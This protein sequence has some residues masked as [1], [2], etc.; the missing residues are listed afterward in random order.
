[1]VKLNNHIN[2]IFQD[3]G[4]HLS[5]DQMK[6]YL[7]HSLGKQEERKIEI[8]IASCGLC[9]EALEGLDMENDF[10]TFET[11]LHNLQKKITSKSKIKTAKIIV[12]KR[13]YMAAAAIIL[14]LIAV[15]FMVYLK[16]NER[17]A[18]EVFAQHYEK[19]DLR[20]GLNNLA[21][22]STDEPETQKDTLKASSRNIADTKSG[23]TPDMTNADAPQTDQLAE[24]PVF[25]S[26][27][28]VIDSDFEESEPLLAKKSEYPNGNNL[29][30][31]E[32]PSNYAGNTAPLSV[33]A[34]TNIVL[35]QADDMAEPEP[36]LKGTYQNDKRESNAKTE[37]YE[38][39]AIDEDAVISAYQADRYQDCINFANQLLEINKN[40]DQ[41]RFY[42]GLSF[43]ALQYPSRAIEDFDFLIN[44]HTELFMDDAK[45]YKALA[46]LDK[47]KKKK[48]I[49]LLKQIKLS[50]SKYAGKA[51]NILDEM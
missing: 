48:A 16:V 8:H 34:D 14:L 30:R 32:K 5:Y 42:R 4:N 40:D 3:S 2:Q 26:D 29:T 17:Y 19:Y 49:S 50:D 36:A 9:S 43:L 7:Q 22:S 6:A 15:S 27:E 38:V 13:K 25:E 1:M 28:Y 45:W 33:V 11:S 35:N 20:K 46:L 10:Q 24:K 39:F 44:K 41:S 18:K 47:G 37:E 23:I 12:F 31:T 51:A 21:I